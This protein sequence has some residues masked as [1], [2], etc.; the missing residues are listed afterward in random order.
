M[1][2]VSDCIKELNKTDIYKTKIKNTN[3][4]ELLNKTKKQITNT[5]SV[6][7]KTIDFIMGIYTIIQYEKIFYEKQSSYASK[8]NNEIIKELK[9]KISPHKLTTKDSISIDIWDINPQNSNKYIIFCEGISSEKSLIDLQKAYAASIK[10]GF[11]VIA[12]NYRGRG[13]SSGYFT[14]KGALKDIETIYKYLLEKGI[15]NEKIGVIGHSMGTGIACDFCSRHKTAFIVLI[16]PFSKAA[17]MAK[18]IAQKLDMPEFVKTMIEK[19][20][21]FLIPLKNV[22]NNEK[23]IKKI[24]SPILILHNTDDETIPVKHGQKLYKQNQNKIYYKEFKN[25]DHEINKE[26]IDFCLNFIET[27]A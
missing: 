14:Q 19:I 8:A 24:K 10:K 27:I 12:F 25:N 5:Q 16:N 7:K 21:S 18:N 17:D 1:Y 9:S 26:K 2:T 15:N 3:F 20:P 22:F 23:A 6:L 4:F 13:E 11:G